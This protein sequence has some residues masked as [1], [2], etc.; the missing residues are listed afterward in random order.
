MQN[1]L[2]LGL[3]LKDGAALAVAQSSRGTPRIAKKIVRRIRDYAQVHEKKV[4]DIGVIHEALTMLGIDK[5]GLTA[6]DHAILTTLVTK[7][8]GGPVG[9]ETIAS[10]V[11]EDST[12]IEDVYEPFLIR[13]GFIEKT[14]RGRQIPSKALLYL[15]KTHHGQTSII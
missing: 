10:I 13:K 3:T 11:G 5:D 12:T 14:S 9:L 4:I 7:F 1:A 15:N 2:F 8:G 6:L